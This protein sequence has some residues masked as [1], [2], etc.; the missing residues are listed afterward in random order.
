[1]RIVN[2]RLQDVELAVFDTLG[3]GDVLFVDSTHVAKVGS[4]VSYLFFE[5]I[6][7]LAAGTFVHIHDVFASF[8]YPLEWLR[9]GRAWNE[10][11]LLHAFLLFNSTFRIRL[12]GNHMV[13]HHPA[14]FRENMPLCL[15]NPGGAF[16]MER[17]SS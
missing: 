17:V 12:F 4:D 6:P 2:S 16:W 5:I 9:E 15:K 3:A 10:Q 1:V 8:E 7:R 14:W 11:Y 13:R